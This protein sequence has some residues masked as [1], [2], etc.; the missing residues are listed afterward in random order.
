MLWKCENV[1]LDIKRKKID[2]N[3]YFCP[4]KFSVYVKWILFIGHVFVSFNKT[5]AYVGNFFVRRILFQFVGKKSKFIAFQ[6]KKIIDLGVQE[7]AEKKII[8]SLWIVILKYKKLHLVIW[9]IILCEWK[10]SIF[11]KTVSRNSRNVR[12]C[13][14]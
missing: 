4:K 2:Q 14:L 6:K 13:A 10:F 11:T 5:A 7:I 1:T 3:S 9:N 8:N 12:F